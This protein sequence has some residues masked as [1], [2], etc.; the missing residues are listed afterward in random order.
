V[1]A[2]NALIREAGNAAHIIGPGRNDSV[3]M[4]AG[5]VGSWPGAVADAVD[6]LS[7]GLP[8]A[9]TARDNARAVQAT[10]D[11]YRMAGEKS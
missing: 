1:S 4:P 11:S 5:Y 9:A 3:T 8:P 6:R 10:F 7:K 2:K